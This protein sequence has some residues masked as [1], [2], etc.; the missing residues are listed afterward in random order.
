[1]RAR[2]AI[3]A[4]AIGALGSTGQIVEARWVKTEREA[5]ALFPHGGVRTAFDIGGQDPP[6]AR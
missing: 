2:D 1:V 5:R 6:G 4:E 3:A